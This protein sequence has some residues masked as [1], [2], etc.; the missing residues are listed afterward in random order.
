MCIVLWDKK[1]GIKRQRK[2]LLG[3]L[4]D[5]LVRHSANDRVNKKSMSFQWKRREKR[6]SD[7]TLCNFVVGLCHVTCRQ[8]VVDVV[9]S[10]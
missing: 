10:C 8:R 5:G 7:E 1:Y 3:I 2:Q 4:F 6:R 9:H